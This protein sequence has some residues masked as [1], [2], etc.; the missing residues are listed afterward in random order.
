M[1]KPTI[2]LL[3]VLLALLGSGHAASSI[4]VASLDPGGVVE[5]RAE[6]PAADPMLEASSTVTAAPLMKK[7]DIVGASGKLTL[8]RVHDVG[9]GFGPPADFIDAEV[10]IRL[11]T[12]IGKSFGFQLRSDTDAL[13]HA[14]MLDLLLD[15]HANNWTVFINY[16]SEAGK[17]NSI[18]F[19]LWV[20]NP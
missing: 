15:A 3:S 16:L 14:G 6:A 11:D 18:M 9:T 2:L 1:N 12:E 8:L 19:R 17:N 5:V 7:V 10:I 20:T 4:S 13:T